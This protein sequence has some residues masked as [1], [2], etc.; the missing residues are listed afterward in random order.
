[1]TIGLSSK[2]MYDSPYVTPLRA[3]STSGFTASVSSKSLGTT[4]LRSLGTS[5]LMASVSCSA[6]K[7][8]TKVAFTKGQ[9]AGTSS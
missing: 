3:S 7:G 1:M 6:V 9:S 4:F 5:C 8:L 2:K